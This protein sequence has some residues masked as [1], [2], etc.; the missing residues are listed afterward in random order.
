MAFKQEMSKFTNKGKT[1]ALLRSALACFSFIGTFLTAAADVMD[2]HAV[3]SPLLS[4]VAY[5]L[6]D[7][8]YNNYARQ[9]ATASGVPS[10]LDG[11]T[12]FK[13]TLAE[14]STFATIFINNSC[15]DDAIRKA[16]GEG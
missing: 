16:F 8:G 13:L 4:E 3:T 2:G 10:I 5:G 7:N 6:T 12:E 1:K 11:S 9:L 14:P 15:L